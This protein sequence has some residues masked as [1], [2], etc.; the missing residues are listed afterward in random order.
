M[1]VIVS[2]LTTPVTVIMEVIG[3]GVHVEVV[4]GFVSVDDVVV[5]D[6]CVE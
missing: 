3:V 5:V 4:D 6:E 2:V 1:G